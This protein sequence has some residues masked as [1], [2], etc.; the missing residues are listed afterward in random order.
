MLSFLLLL[1]H[2]PQRIFFLMTYSG[3][4]TA[5]WIFPIP[6]S[7]LPSDVRVDASCEDII[8]CNWQFPPPF[9]QGVRPR[10]SYRESQCVHTNVKN[11]S[12]WFTNNNFFTKKKKLHLC[13]KA[14]HSLH[15]KIFPAVFELCTSL[16]V[17]QLGLHCR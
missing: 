13:W 17:S 1:H 10:S 4:A 6:L 3:A 7:I 14:L 2:N 5:P 8:L 9:C 12:P 11:I 15:G 16:P